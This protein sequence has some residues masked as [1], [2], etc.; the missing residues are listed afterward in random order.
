MHRKNGRALPV[1]ATGNLAGVRGGSPADSGTGGGYYVVWDGS[2]APQFGM[3]PPGISGA[4]GMTGSNDLS[5]QSADEQ[6]PG[7]VSALL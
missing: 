1:L 7:L 2:G 3:I 5:G 4:P 6:Q